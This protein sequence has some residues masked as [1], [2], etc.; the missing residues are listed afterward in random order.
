MRT[1]LY[2]FISINTSGTG[3]CMLGMLSKIISSKIY[4]AKYLSVSFGGYFSHSTRKSVND[5]KK[6]Q[7]SEALGD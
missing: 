7:V 1:I 3:Q 6:F 4:S 2:L 5:P